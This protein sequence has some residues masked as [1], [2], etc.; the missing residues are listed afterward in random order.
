MTTLIAR[1]KHKELSCRGTATFAKSTL[2]KAL[3]SQHTKFEESQIRF[4]LRRTM[5]WFA[6]IFP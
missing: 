1:Q 2:L 4:G 3:Q 5:L 6:W